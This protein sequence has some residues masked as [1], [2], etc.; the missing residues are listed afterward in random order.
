[1]PRTGYRGEGI[2]GLN[3]LF[4]T[5]LGKVKMG[6]WEQLDYLVTT[7]EIVIDRPKGSTHPKFPDMVYPFNY[8]YLK[9]TSSGDGNEIDV[10]RGS[11]IG[12]RLMAIICTIDSHKKDTEVKLIVDCTDD[13]MDIIGLLFNS[14]K[15]GAGLIIRREK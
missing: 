3:I 12:N 4:L 10:C 6:F 9:N 14:D 5:G 11:L 13:E 8:G 2:N 15:Y 1:L 7:N